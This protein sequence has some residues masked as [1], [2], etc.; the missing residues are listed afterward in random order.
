MRA[1]GLAVFFV[2]ILTGAARAERD[3]ERSLVGRAASLIERLIGVAPRDR[4]IIS[5][6]AD[7]DPGMVIA[8]PSGG[9]LRVVPPPSRLRQQ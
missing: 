7:R 2:A 3:D 6:P 4:D 1:I 9:V 8:P 5:P